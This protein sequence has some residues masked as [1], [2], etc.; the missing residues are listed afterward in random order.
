MPAGGDGRALLAHTRACTPPDR[1]SPA[2][3]LALPAVSH[4]RPAT[5]GRSDELPYRPGDKFSPH[6]RYRTLDSLTA[7]AAA[8]A[9]HRTMYPP[10]GRLRHRRRGSTRLIGRKR[11]TTLAGRRLLLWR[12]NVRIVAEFDSTHRGYCG[13]VNC[14]LHRLFNLVVKYGGLS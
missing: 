13:H 7:A 5:V 4:R 14:F 8:A 2:A 10:A 11:Q 3:R 1:Y 12:Q 6:R 9:C